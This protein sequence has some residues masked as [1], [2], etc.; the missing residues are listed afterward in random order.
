MKRMKTI[1]PIVAPMATAAAPPGVR[2]PDGPLWAVACVEDVDKAEELALVEAK[3][4]ASS[5]N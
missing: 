3:T 2:T 1:P 4:L 5:V